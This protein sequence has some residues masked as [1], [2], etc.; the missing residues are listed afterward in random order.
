MTR[1]YGVRPKVYERGD[2]RHIR[3]QLR[4]LPRRA[5]AVMPQWWEKEAQEYMRDE[6][7]IGLDRQLC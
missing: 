2:A 6:L 7:G 3:R 4:A 5:D 1:C